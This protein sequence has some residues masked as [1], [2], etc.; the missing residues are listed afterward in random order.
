M[1]WSDKDSAESQQAT[2]DYLEKQ[3]IRVTDINNKYASKEGSRSN[4]SVSFVKASGS[5]PKEKYAIAQAKAK[6]DA[7]DEAALKKAAEEAAE[8][9]KA[10][11]AKKDAEKGSVAKDLVD[12]GSTILLT[13]K[14]T[15]Q[16]NGWKEGQFIDREFGPGDMIYRNSEGT[17]VFVSRS[18][19]RKL[20]PHA[21]AQLPKSSYSVTKPLKINNDKAKERLEGIFDEGNM[22]PKLRGETASLLESNKGQHKHRAIQTLLRNQKGWESNGSPYEVVQGSSVI[23]RDAPESMKWLREG[24]LAV[25]YTDKNNAWDR[26]RGDDQEKIKD[27]MGSLG[28][29][30]DSSHVGAQFQWSDDKGGS[31]YDRDKFLIFKPK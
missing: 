18:D 10:E 5:A 14:G 30:Y 27:F 17:D 22:T 7:A 3:G 16:T 21:L 28:L 20:A 13:E 8:V 9:A 24:K 31:G 26:P 29:K 11:Q 19:A 1:A 12:S 15:L 25:R 6:K 4:F 2:I 23:E